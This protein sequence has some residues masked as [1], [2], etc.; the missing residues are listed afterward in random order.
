MKGQY[1]GKARWIFH[2]DALKQIAKLKDGDGQYIWQQGIQLGAP[3]RL[4]GIPVLM[5]EY[6]PNTFSGSAYVGIIGDF[7][8]YWI[9]DSLDLTIKRLVEL[10][11]ATDQIGYIAKME[12][13]GMPVLAEAFARVRLV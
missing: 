4:L 7:S 9:A 10:Y 1:W 11:A 12:I 3:D 5:S 6:A 8:F 13:D 2:R